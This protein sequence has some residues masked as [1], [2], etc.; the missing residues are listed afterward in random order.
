MC[1]LVS[2]T[3]AK[4]WAELTFMAGDGGDGGEWE[5]CQATDRDWHWKFVTVKPPD[6]FNELSGHF[7]LCVV[8]KPDILT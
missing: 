2:S 1:S 7:Q 5:G 3:F 8:M 4:S 6:I